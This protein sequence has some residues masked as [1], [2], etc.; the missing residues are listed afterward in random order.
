MDKKLKT[1]NNNNKIQISTNSLN[2]SS[3]SKNSLRIATKIKKV[4]KNL[5]NV[6]RT[7]KKADYSFFTITT[8]LANFNKFNYS[9][10]TIFN[11]IR[12]NYSYF[13]NFSIL[14]KIDIK[15]RN[16]TI[17]NSLSTNFF[18]CNLSLNFYNFSI[19]EKITNFNYY[20]FKLKFLESSFY[21][22]QF[23]NHEY[24]NWRGLK[25]FRVL[26][27]ISSIDYLLILLEKNLIGEK[28]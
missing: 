8:V 25:N 14:S 4:N 17:F 11:K 6:S 26:Q 21:S 15:S 23:T 2:R 27:N 20:T 9:Y 24:Y 7:S 28:L 10:F 19:V 16:F 3:L 12:F 22:Y 1:F 5:T 13:T 18:K